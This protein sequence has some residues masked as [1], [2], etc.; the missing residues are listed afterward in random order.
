MRGRSLHLDA[1]S[2]K[3]TFA[4]YKRGPWN[5]GVP[6]NVTFVRFLALTSERAR[7]E[8]TLTSPITSLPHEPQVF[9]PEPASD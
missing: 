9:A 1:Y 5:G 8:E 7:P 2:F 6:A 4:A 3:R